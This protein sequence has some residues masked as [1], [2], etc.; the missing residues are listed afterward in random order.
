MPSEAFK[1]SSK[2]ELSWWGVGGFA[3]RAIWNNRSASFFSTAAIA[4][5]TLL[6]QWGA[7]YSFSTA[8][9]AKIIGG[10]ATYS[11][12]A[13]GVWWL[14]LVVGLLLLAPMWY[15]RDV[16]A[17]NEHRWVQARMEL[18]QLT[19]TSQDNRRAL[20][21]WLAE[22]IRDMKPLAER[23]RLSIAR[24]KQIHEEISTHFNI[25]NRNVIARLHA[26]AP[27]WVPFYL[28]NQHGSQG[29]RSVPMRE[30]TVEA[31]SIMLAVNDIEYIREQLK[32]YVAADLMARVI[33]RENA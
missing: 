32:E 23:I 8:G 12:V 13:V 17:E 26:D 21:A 25:L 19:K 5:L 22:C 24:D 28:R 31:R 27:E 18:R 4:L 11:L 7:A 3:W 6:I 33:E 30:P 2:V 1:V 10:A 20:N 16:I 14:L 9:W 15:A 29:G